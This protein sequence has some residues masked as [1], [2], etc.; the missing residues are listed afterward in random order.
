MVHSFK[1]TQKHTYRAQ[2]P[3]SSVCLSYRFHQGLE[4]SSSLVVPRRAFTYSS[5]VYASAVEVALASFSFVQ[6]AVLTEKLEVLSSLVDLIRDEAPG[7]DGTSPHDQGPWCVPLGWTRRGSMLDL[8]K[9]WLKDGASKK[10]GQLAPVQKIMAEDF[11]ME[12]SASGI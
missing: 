12:L 1:E 6:L 10:P 8:A 7:Y 5:G 9:K 11:D 4:G 3:Q 2:N